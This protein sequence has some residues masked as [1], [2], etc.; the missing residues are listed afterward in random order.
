[1]A[2]STSDFR[3]SSSIGLRFGK[4]Y[5]WTFNRKNQ[6]TLHPGGVDGKCT[7]VHYNQRGDKQ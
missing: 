5:H 3:G 4:L 6:L 7:R 2:T 1:M